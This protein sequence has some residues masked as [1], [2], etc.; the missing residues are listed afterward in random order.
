MLENRERNSHFDL[1]VFLLL[2]GIVVGGGADLILDAPQGWTLHVI[3]EVAL[4][5]LS[6]GSASY[7][8]WGWYQ[9]QGHLEATR[10]ALAK[11]E[12]EQYAW[13]KDA[14][15]WLTGLRRSIEEQ[16]DRW[17]LSPTERA[18]ALMLLKGHSHKQI[19]ALSS[20]SE[21]TV[22]QQAVAVYRKSQLGGRAELAAFF[23]DGL[24]L[25]VTEKSAK[26]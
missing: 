8:A 18:T 22:R 2:A 13:E 6:L 1:F 21:R 9:T 25:P 20:K 3:L 4:I 7:L 23:L 10:L 16:L 15:Q 12:E 5:L 24:F 19:A 11:M 14:Q 17:S 26:R